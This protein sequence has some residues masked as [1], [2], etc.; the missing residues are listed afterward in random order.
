VWGLWASGVL[1][2]IPQ[3]REE[4][5]SPL[6][7]ETEPHAERIRGA[8]VSREL[9][10]FNELHRMLFELVT[11]ELRD[12]AG[13]LFERAFARAINEHGDL[14][15]GVAVDTG[16]ELDSFALRKNIA[17]REISTYVKGL[18]RLL[19]IETELARELLGERKAAIIQ[20]GLLVLKQRQLEGTTTT[21]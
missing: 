11:Y 10:R 18:E 13:L 21:P 1:D 5:L 6:R 20:D 9:D 8:S 2:R 14:Y 12:R 16:G 17:T 19:E 3:D 15:E 7:E 4:P